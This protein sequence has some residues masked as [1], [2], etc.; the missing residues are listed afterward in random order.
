MISNT[1][2]ARLAQ[3]VVG[4]QGRLCGDDP[5]AAGAGPRQRLQDD[6]GGSGRARPPGAGKSGPR[7]RGRAQ[8]GPDLRQRVYPVQRRFAVDLCRHRS[9]ESR[10]AGPHAIRHIFDAAGVPSAHNTSTTSSISAAPIRSGYRATSNS[11]AL[12]RTSPVSKPATHPARWCRS[13]R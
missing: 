1:V 6:A 5:A 3:A 9:D 10:K 2:L 8:Q 4:H 11:G 13:G 12:R 7:S